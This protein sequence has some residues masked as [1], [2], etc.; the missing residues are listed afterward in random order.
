[1]PGAPSLFWEIHHGLPREGAGDN[2]S[3]RKAYAMLADLPA[4]PD[5]LD[6]GCGPGMQ[7]LELAR[8]SNANLSALDKH[9]PFLDEL[10]H[11]A[12][13]AGLADRIKTVNASM[14]A[15]PFGDER[16]DV[17]WAEGAIFI[18][19]VE[20]GLAHWKPFLKNKGYIVFTH[21][22]WL[23]T[24]PPHEIKAFWN[25]N[26]PQMQ[27]IEGVLHTIKLSGLNPISHF[28]LPDS[29]WWDD[30]YTPLNN[31]L[32]ALREQYARDASMLEMIDETQSEI[33]MRRK[34]ATS[35]GY[36]FFVTQGS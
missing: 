17:I 7:T 1:M 2:A 25:K 23:E 24:N 36:V 11:M 6:I 18:I 29:A 22:C 9:Q 15:L 12:V 35:Y 13:D 5:I 4:N 10:N 28:T 26:F 8:I 34:Y 30:Y 33:D 16:F 21:I 32:I 19:G 27:D 3:T 20:K 14:S 31:R